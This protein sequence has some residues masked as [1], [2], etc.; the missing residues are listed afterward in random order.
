MKDKFEIMDMMMPIG[1]FSALAGAVVA[2]CCLEDSEN[3]V[4]I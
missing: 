2:L 3:P 4:Q 1:K